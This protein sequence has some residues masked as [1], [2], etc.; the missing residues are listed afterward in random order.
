MG[1]QAQDEIYLSWDDAVHRAQQRYEAVIEAYRSGH[2][3]SR[4][5]L[6]EEYYETLAACVPPP[7][8]A[9]APTS[10]TTGTPSPSISIKEKAPLC[11]GSWP[12][13]PE[14]S[15]PRRSGKR[16]PFQGAGSAQ[17]RPRGCID[18]AT[19]GCLR[20]PYL[21]RLAGKDRGEKGRLD[22]FGAVCV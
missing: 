17:P 7:S 10:A 2:S 22:A 19:A 15:I 18:F 6:A 4:R 5:S 12:E 9:A 21:F 8:N 1:R 14:G 16:L 20:R 3:E 11:K 13:G